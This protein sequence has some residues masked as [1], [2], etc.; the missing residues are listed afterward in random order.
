MKKTLIQVNL[1]N[2]AHCQQLLCL[3]NHYMEDE[4]GISQS[5]PEELGP[6]IIDGLRKHSAYLGFFV[7][8]D[9]DYVALANC[10]LNYSTWAAR[11]L[12]NIHDFIVSSNYRKQGVGEFLMNGIEA[13][14]AENGYCKINLEVRHDNVKAQA[15]Y[16]KM[17]FTDCA[18]PMYF[19]QKV[20]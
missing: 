17:G 4:M 11:F 1:E 7:C 12:I 18:P 8:M 3:L 13:Y 6:K 15:L 2:P 20:L 5:M 9:D 10:N 16:K 19:W 14:A